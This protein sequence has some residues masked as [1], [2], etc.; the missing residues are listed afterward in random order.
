MTRSVAK[1]MSAEPT[2]ISAWER[3]EGGERA[4]ARTWTIGSQK[5][6]SGVLQKGEPLILPVMAHVMQST[7][8]IAVRNQGPSLAHTVRSVIC[9]S[10][11]KPL[12]SV[13]CPGAPAMAKLI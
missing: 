4:R 10:S 12:P 2:R 3:G 11:Q 1:M 6:K 5:E 9:S 7:D 13:H 8:I